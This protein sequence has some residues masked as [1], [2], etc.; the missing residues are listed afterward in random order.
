MRKLKNKLLQFLQPVLAMAS[1]GFDVN[2]YA[3]PF[4]LTK[5]LQKDVYPIVDPT[6]NFDLRADNKVVLIIGGAGS[7]GFVSR[8]M[9]L[10]P[11]RFLSSKI[12]HFRP[13]QR[14]G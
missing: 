1:K 14:L 9:T 10:Y 3:S 8:T 2:A 11:Y 7:F 5:S 6:Q 13:L 12:D 4:M